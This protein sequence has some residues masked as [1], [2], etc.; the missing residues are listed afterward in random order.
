M[1]E[2]N[3]NKQIG[4]KGE[5]IACSY[6]KKLGWKILEK[7]FRYSKYAE[8]DIIAKETNTIVFVEVKTR[9]TSNFGHPFEAI[10]TKKINN[11][12]KAALSYLKS[13]Q[14]RYEDYR[15]DIISILGNSNPKIEHIKNISLN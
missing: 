2:K 10:N 12:Y 3:I 9:T 13:T 7:N 11:I 4:T 6:L 5:E 1:S 14:E 8:I 15:I